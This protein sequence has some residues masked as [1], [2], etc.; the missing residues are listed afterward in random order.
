MAI[1][2]LGL[3]KCPICDELL[4]ETHKVIGLPAISGKHGDI[5]ERL[6]DA[7]VHEECLL[8]MEGFEEFRNALN[9]EL[10]R[11]MRRQMDESGTIVDLS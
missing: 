3:S 11:T 9:L 6:N 2:L 4:E 5:F 8:E 1:I 7:G 10:E